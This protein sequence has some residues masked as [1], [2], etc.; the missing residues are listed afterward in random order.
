MLNLNEI[1]PDNDGN[2]PDLERPEFAC[3]SAYADEY[4]HI[5]ALSETL[6]WN[7]EWIEPEWRIGT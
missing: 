7:S 3:S 5:L 2:Y 6:D 1:S 4:G